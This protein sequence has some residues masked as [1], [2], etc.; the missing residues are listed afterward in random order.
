MF[1]Q[2]F[3]LGG[4]LPLG[5]ILHR[6][7]PRTKLIG[8]LPL[9]GT[10]FLSPGFEGLVVCTAFIMGLAFLTGAGFRIWWNALRRFAWM[11]AIVLTVNLLLRQEG[12]PLYAWGIELPVTWEGLSYGLAFSVQI[13]LAIVASLVVT[14]TTT[15]SQLVRA[16]EALARPLERLRVPVGDF[17]IIIGLAIRFLPLLHQEIRMLADAQRSRGV[18]FRAGSPLVRARHLVSVLVPALSNALLRADILATAMVMRGFQPGKKRS[19][20]RELRFSSRDYLAWFCLA[21]L[22]SCRIVL[23]C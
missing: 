12:K 6:L 14:I 19:T 7:D 22:F 8:L 3:T 5:S 16:M 18:D 17:A 9:L 23:P 1:S 10:L 15:P 2:G 4:Y 11:L 20:Y 13:L 21:S